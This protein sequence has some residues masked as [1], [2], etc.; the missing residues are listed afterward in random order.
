[1]RESLC[2]FVRVCATY[3]CVRVCECVCVYMCAFL[4]ACMRVF[5]REYVCVFAYKLRW[6]HYAWWTRLAGHAFSLVPACGHGRA[7]L[8]SRRKAA[9]HGARP[10]YFIFLCTELEAE[11]ASIVGRA[12]IHG[13]GSSSS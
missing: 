9:G 2:A 4:R 3:E 1:M 5:V 13:S 7:H 10:L 6:I 11:R 12:V 8:R